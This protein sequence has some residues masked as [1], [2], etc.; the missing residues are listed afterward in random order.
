MSSDIETLLTASVHVNDVEIQAFVQARTK[1][2][3]SI[4]GDTHGS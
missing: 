2:I 4:K 1:L 3:A